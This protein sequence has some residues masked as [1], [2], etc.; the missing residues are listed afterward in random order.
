MFTNE[1]VYAKMQRRCQLVR[2]KVFAVSERFTP[3]SLQ[4]LPYG[5]KCA[6][7]VARSEAF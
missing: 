1:V 4:F 6:L 3:E 5:Q 7:Y 2:F